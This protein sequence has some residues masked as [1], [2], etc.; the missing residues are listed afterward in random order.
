M[1]TYIAAP[2]V[3][4]E[5]AKSAAHQCV[6]AGLKIVSTWHERTAPN[7]VD[8]AIQD[9][10]DLWDADALLLLNTRL[11]EGKAVECGWALAHHIHVVVVG[12]RSD[13]NIFHYLPEVTMVPTVA[14]AIEYL[15]DVEKPRKT[16][17]DLY[18]YDGCGER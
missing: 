17:L 11:S 14:A 3:D 5:L 18:T 2:W 10:N 7:T 16:T 15:Q 13:A 4:R 8:Q 1:N 12:T 6:W 9:L